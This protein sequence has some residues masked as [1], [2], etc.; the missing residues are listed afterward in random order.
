[1]AGGT[2]TPRQKMINMM[3]L[4]LTAMLALNVS[5][6]VLDAFVV[7]DK[8]IEHN[9]RIVMEKNSN[10]LSDFRR[11]AAENR[12]KVEP[13]LLKGEDVHR[14]ATEMYSMINQLKLDLVISGDGRDSESI[15]DGEVNA[16]LI[17]S[18]SDTDASSRVLVGSGTFKGKAFALR[19]AMNEYSDYL[20]TLIDETKSPVLYHS[21]VEMLRLPE[22]QQKTDGDVTSWEV[23]TFD[24]VP[25]I[26]AVAILSKMQMDVYNSESE[27]VSYLMR[28]ISATDFKFSDIDVAVIPSSNYVIQGTEFSAEMFLAAYD[29][30]QSPVLTMGGRSYHANDKGKIVFKTVPEHIGP[31]SLHGNIE[32]IGT[33][34]KT[35]R[36]V[37]VSYMVVEPNTVVSPAKMNVVYRGIENP[38]NVSSAGIPQDKLDVRITNGTIERKGNEFMVIPGS[39]RICEIS[40]FVDEKNMGTRQLRVKDLP[41]PTPQLDVIQGKTATKSE[42]LASQG[43][44]AAMP[45]DFDFDLRFR[46]V[47]F[48]VFVPDATSGYVLEEESKSA[49]FTDRQKQIF[50]RVRSGQR[51]TFTDIKA[52]GPDGRT[53]DLNDFSIKIK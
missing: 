33:D 50:N 19:N 21:L 24:A 18:L 47:S 28:Q 30:T 53:I 10:N 43:I 16:A 41:P 35:T 6:E 22:T 45:R 13:W 31:V 12:E 7:I 51:V 29:P 37:N 5:A 46:V 17:G 40:V 34:G 11:A 15:I 52:V 23:A 32:F 36:P 27:V 4:V 9:T 2:L 49:A 39:G 1:M 3:Y 38:V 20:L 25:L 14:R 42:L 26:S 8:S 44:L 48:S